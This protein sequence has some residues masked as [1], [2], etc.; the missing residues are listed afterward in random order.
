[1][2]GPYASHHAQQEA[3]LAERSRQEIAKIG[4]NGPQRV[5]AVSKWITG[6]VGEADARPIRA[7][8]VTDSHLRFYEAIM[9]KI[10]SQGAASFSQSHRVPAED[11]G[12]IP[13]FE[14][15]SFEQRRQAQDRNAARGR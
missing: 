2:M 4:T 15:M 10:V 3:A 1:M 9:S 14:N 12:K 8:I 7:T 11:S 5:D 6:I 13:V